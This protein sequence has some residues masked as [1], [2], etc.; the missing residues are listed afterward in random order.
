[1]MPLLLFD[2]IQ[3]FKLLI[4]K[5]SKMVCMIRKIS[6]KFYLKYQV[7]FFFLDFHDFDMLL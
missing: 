3:K 1:M 4:F 2:S 5:L 6:F 7:Q